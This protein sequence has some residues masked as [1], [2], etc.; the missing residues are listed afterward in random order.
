MG[1]L[2]VETFDDLYGSSTFTADQK[3]QA[4]AAANAAVES[5][6]GQAFDYQTVRQWVRGSGTDAIVLSQAPAY[7]IS[8][9]GFGRTEVARLGNT[10]AIKGLSVSIA[11]TPWRFN[12]FDQVEGRQ[13]LEPD[14]SAAVLLSDVPALT[15]GWSLTIDADEALAAI[16]PVS[17]SGENDMPLYGP[18]E[19]SG[20]AVYIDGDRVLKL[21]QG[22]IFQPG[23]WHYV[24]FVAGYQTMPA[25]LL[26][27][28]FSIARAMVKSGL[29]DGTIKKQKL[30]DWSYE[31]SDSGSN[32]EY[33]PD[34]LALLAPYMRLRL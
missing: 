25:D 5:M 19:D 8:R 21:Q 31:L 3:A 12:W 10:G 9:I 16:Q 17:L 1:V 34:A 4:V 13:T 32:Q 22:Q 6:A 30:G 20:A 28:T 29:A 26:Q 33:P 2:T 27:G 7:S 18:G 23:L 11:P 14:L 15:D 24:E